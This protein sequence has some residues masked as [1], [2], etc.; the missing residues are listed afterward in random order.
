M[1]V[2]STDFITVCKYL[3]GYNHAVGDLRPDLG[4]GGL[5][6]FRQ[7][8]AVRLYSCVKS[9]WSEIILREDT[10]DD[11]F[12]AL[13]Q[14]YD[15]FESDRSVRGLGT[16]LADF[17]RRKWRGAIKNDRTCWCELPPDEQKQWRPGYR[18]STDSLPPGRGT[19]E[20]NCT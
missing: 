11:K 16:I 6:G 19:D 10:G 12:A 9:D 5:A 3:S 1:Y 17:E 20:L 14:L 15:E 18:R 8:L 7:W 13:V 4:D 2:G